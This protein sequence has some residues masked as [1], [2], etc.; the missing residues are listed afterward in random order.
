MTAARKW[1]DMIMADPQTPA[2]VRSRAD[3]LSDLIAA[4]NKG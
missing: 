4:S 1:T 3:V 2:G